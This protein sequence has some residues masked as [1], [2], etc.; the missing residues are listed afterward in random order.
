V[1]GP[2]VPRTLIL[3]NKYL[4]LCTENHAKWPT[5]S[6]SKA[7]KPHSSQFFQ[8]QK[9]S[10]TDVMIIQRAKEFP[11]YFGIVFEEE[12]N[13]DVVTWD[14]IAHTEQEKDKFLGRLSKLWE[15]IF[16]IPLHTKCY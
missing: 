2:V 14:I 5:L 8:E 4:I 13:P 15:T 11:N 9:Q 10:L 12:N 16:Q 6:I 7:P 1:P 3:T